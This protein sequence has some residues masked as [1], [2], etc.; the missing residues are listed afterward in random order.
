MSQ[1][2]EY[3]VPGSDG[4]RAAL[5]EILRQ[6]FNFLRE[7][8]PQFFEV[9]GHEN[10]RVLRHGGSVVGGLVI[11]HMGQYF[12]GRSVKM[13]GIAAVGIDPHM[14]GQ[15]A[16][17]AL[18]GAAVREMHGMG[19]PITSLYPATQPLYQRAGYEQ[20][21]TFYR[22]ILPTAAIDARHRDLHLREIAPAD[23]ADVE[24]CYEQRARHVNGHLDRGPYVWTRARHH[25]NEPA[26]GFLVEGDHGV[27]GYVY[28][29]HQDSPT[30]SYNL[31]CTDLV[32]ITQT[33]ALRL[34][35]FFADH[36]SMVGDVI[37][38]GHP[39]DALHQNLREQHI[40]D[41]V[42]DQWMLR[43]LDV[44]KALEA[45]GYEPG[46]S[47]EIH[48]DVHDDAVL[49]E[50][51]HGRWLL[52]VEGGRATVQREAGRGDVRVSV[53]GLASLYSGLL[54]P[55]Q[56]RAAGRLEGSDEAIAPLSA[57]FGGGS[58]WLAD[59]F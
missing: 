55:W 46:V 24:Q 20:A 27:E 56:A 28:Y 4:E 59:H 41:E 5:G 34:L 49:P 31:Y 9:S 1:D 22:C 51:N 17:S 3:G 38:H 50:I 16:A 53:R 6:T 11:V 21:G 18:M 40:R 25:R 23:L 7:R 48:L 36:R 35:R 45:R 30:R 2:F 39:G 44:G 10:L 19:Y 43:L 13:A 15:G 47:A 8:V 52:R 33:A 42:K 37:W 32:A 14:R 26:R 29:A 12:G 57:I 54:T 58:P